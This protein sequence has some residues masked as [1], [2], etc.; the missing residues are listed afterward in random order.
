MT[1]KLNLTIEE[2]IAAK[3]K[4]YAEKRKTSVSRITEEYFKTLLSNKK[5][6][7]KSMV[8]KHQEILKKYKSVP[9]FDIDRAKDEYLKEKYGL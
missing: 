1:T 7:G 4:L 8:S 6:T 9:A 3:I 2:D 5:A